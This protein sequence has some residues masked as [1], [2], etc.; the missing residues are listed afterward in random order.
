MLRTVRGVEAGDRR[1]VGRWRWVNRHTPLKLADGFI[2][3]GVQVGSVTMV[4]NTTDVSDREVVEIIERF[5]VPPEKAREM[6]RKRQRRAA[7]GYR[8]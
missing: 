2:T 8:G 5:D 3:K 6:A 1:N 4:R 7:S